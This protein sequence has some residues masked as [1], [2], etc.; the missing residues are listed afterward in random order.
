VIMVKEFYKSFPV[1]SKNEIDSERGFRI[2]AKTILLKVKDFPVQSIS[3]Q[4][5]DKEKLQ[6]GS[7][8]IGNHLI[9]FVGPDLANLEYLCC[10]AE[11][12]NGKSSENPLERFNLNI[13]RNN[14]KRS[15][16]LS[17][18]IN[19]VFPKKGQD[20][21]SLEIIFPEKNQDNGILESDSI[22]SEAVVGLTVEIASAIND[23]PIIPCVLLGCNAGTMSYPYSPDK[24]IRAINFVV[25]IKPIKKVEMQEQIG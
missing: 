13:Y 15:K 18:T 20:I 5:L 4:E 21:K 10:Q 24:S 12:F 3:G 25:N 8:Q 19:I 17:E 22:S 11:H 16:H 6:I 14:N 1:F 2:L 7:A 9:Y 23:L